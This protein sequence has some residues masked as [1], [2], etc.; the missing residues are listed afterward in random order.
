MIQS[1]SSLNRVYLRKNLRLAWP[2]ALNALLMQSMLIIDTLLVSPLG[3]VPLAAMGIAAT[4]IAFALGVQLALANGTQLLIGKAFG[5]KQHGAMMSATLQGFVINLVTALLFIGLLLLG[6]DALV[7]GLT[8]NPGVAQKVS[9]YLVVGQFIL[10][11]NA[12][13]QAIIA[14]FNGRG[15]TQTPFHAYLIEL[16]FNAL[17]SY[18]LIFGVAGFEGV[19]FI[20]AAFGS[21]AAVS[22]RLSYLLLAL[23]KT[24][25]LGCFLTNLEGIGGHCREILP[26]AANFMLLST[27]HTLYQLLFAQLNLYSYVAITLVFPWLRIATQFIVAW[28]QANSISITQAIGSGH[29]DHLKP[30]VSSC[31]K[32]GLVM[33]C[34]VALVLLLFSCSVEWIYPKV[35]APT[36]LAIASIA[37]LF[38]LLPLV[39]TFNTIAGTSLRAMG[40]SISVLKVHFVTQWFIGLPLCALSVLYFEWGLVWAFAILPLEEVLKSWPFYKML[41]ARLAEG[42]P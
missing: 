30:I 25:N 12:L 29:Q 26:I 14:Y 10:I 7:S 6:R 3:E 15:E 17:V 32:L 28:A 36:Y 4:L 42:V 11:V 33:A 2:L 40:Q 21:L 16:P 5:A 37:P 1:T 41:K 27:G 34:G 18:C 13:S 20:G 22:L 8:D 35:E 23:A 9:D 31:V 24:E 19:G 38:I 39:R